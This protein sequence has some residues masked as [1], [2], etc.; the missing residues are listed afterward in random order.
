MV[1]GLRTGLG[2]ANDSLGVALALSSLLGLR[3]II[4]KTAGGH[5]LEGSGSNGRVGHTPKGTRLRFSQ[6]MMRAS[7]DLLLISS[8]GQGQTSFIS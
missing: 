1:S 5:S 8:V 7:I 4:Y 3:L 6:I 2:G